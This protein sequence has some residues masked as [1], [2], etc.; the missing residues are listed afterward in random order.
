MGLS[1]L[2]I[3]LLGNDFTSVREKDGGFLYS[4][5]EIQ[6]MKFIYKGFIMTNIIYNQNK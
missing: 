5:N 4:L 3:L 1:I 6:K 2:I